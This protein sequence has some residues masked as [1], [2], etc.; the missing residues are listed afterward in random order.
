[1][2]KKKAVGTKDVNA[3][4]VG[5]VDGAKP[6]LKKEVPEGSH[7]VE[8]LVENIM[9]VRV[10]HIKPKHN[11]IQLTGKNGQGKTSVLRA[12]AWAL[13]G[14]SD[15]PTQP[16]R[17]GQRVG[18]IKMDL[19]DLVVTRHFTR[20]EEDK[21]TKGNTYITKL[22][23]EGKKREQFRSPQT[24]LDALMGKISFDPLAFIR[25]GQQTGGDKK[26]LET[27][28]EL[29]TFD[30]DIDELDRQQEADYEERKVA[31][32]EIDS[33]TPRLAA[34]TK[35]QEG[36]PAEPIDTSE[37]TKRLEGAANH[38][39]VVTAKRQEKARLEEQAAGALRE[40]QRLHDEAISLLDRAMAQDG[41]KYILSRQDDPEGSGE[42][43]RL[44][45]LSAAITVGDEIDT[46]AVVQELTKANETNRAIQYVASYKVVE[47]ELQVAT[48]EWELLDK[49][50]KART[51]ERAAAIAR[52]KMP[53]DGLSIG[54]GEVL[55]K[56]LP[57]GQASNAEQ[58]RVSMALAMAS[59]PKLRVLRISDG[60]LLDSDSM[61]LITAAAEEHGFQVWI[62]MSDELIETTE[63]EKPRE[64]KI[65]TPIGMSQ[66]CWTGSTL[67]GIDSR[68]RV[69]FISQH[70]GNWKLHG[71]PIEPS[72]ETWDKIHRNRHANGEHVEVRK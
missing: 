68:G 58:I 30:I 51:Q 23:V 59:N 17:A 39:S 15:I 12:I 31:G 47:Q 55:Y 70:D 54:N 56:G 33:R 13:T 53:I 21:S 41:R 34:M 37:I 7:I 9:K 18:S 63:A 19:G 66:L 40:A 69:W 11:V 45:A 27:L 8:L 35:P 10:A 42:A 49:R 65:I 43:Q 14:T 32:R 36:L 62:E 61:D 16:I 24:V 28:R 67:Y 1:M 6:K 26:Q 57:F 46:A 29:V 38:N 48:E 64:P 25:M 22:T 5:Q 72:I 44:L 3:V 50:I 4:E 20:V 60:S 52:A 2:A 71:N